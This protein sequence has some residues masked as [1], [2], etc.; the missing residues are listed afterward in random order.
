MHVPVFA[1]PEP[2][3]SGASKAVAA[4]YYEERARRDRERS[5]AVHVAA[6]FLSSKHHRKKISV[7]CSDELVWHLYRHFK[8]FESNFQKAPAPVVPAAPRQARAEASPFQRYLRTNSSQ[9]DSDEAPES[10]STAPL[11]QDQ[12]ER[13]AFMAECGLWRGMRATNGL[14]CNTALSSSELWRAVGHQMPRLARLFRVVCSLAGST[15]AVERQIKQNS[16]IHTTERNCLSLESLRS[17]L[18]VRWATVSGLYQP[19][20]SAPPPKH[21]RK[22]RA[23]GDMPSAASQDLPPPSPAPSVGSVNLGSASGSAEVV[24]VTTEEQLAASSRALEE[25]I[26]NAVD[27]WNAQETEGI[28]LELT[29]SVCPTSTCQERIVVPAPVRRS[30]RSNLGIDTREK[31]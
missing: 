5:I 20:R 30:T 31:L 18:L 3:A 13:Q 29:A 21:T 16:L 25:E 6:A 17:Q 11:T 1:P 7:I 2:L 24:V 9:E 10:I 8:L 4:K 22:R 26:D 27:N 19:W 23:I 28:L 15:A 14:Y 12:L